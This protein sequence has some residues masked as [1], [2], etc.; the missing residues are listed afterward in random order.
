MIIF[1]DDP[2][3]V[4]PVEPTIFEGAIETTF[5]SVTEP[6]AI[7]NAIS[8]F[9]A[10]E[11]VTSPTKFNEASIG[12]YV[13]SWLWFP[14]AK[15]LAV[16]PAKDETFSHAI[17]PLIFVA[18]NEDTVNLMFFD[19]SDFTESEVAPP[20]IWKVTLFFNLFAVF[21]FPV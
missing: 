17:F 15:E 20:V 18:S 7:L 3:V 14:N 13:V 11:P 2:I 6:S 5:V 4:F 16:V 1:V 8:E 9:I 12:A 10:P 19:K 21:A